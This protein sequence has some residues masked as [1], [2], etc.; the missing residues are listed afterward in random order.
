MKKQAVLIVAHDQPELLKINMRRLDSNRVDIYIHLDKKCKIKESDLT[1]VCKKSNVYI[2]KKY[3]PIWG[4]SP[5]IDVE[6]LL[7][8]KAVSTYEYSYYHLISGRDLLLGNVDRFCD[9]FENADKEFVSFQEDKILDIHKDRV[10][11]YYPFTRFLGRRGDSPDRHLVDFQKKLNINRIR[12]TSLVFQKG[13]NWFSITHKLALHV[14]ETVSDKK[15]RKIFNCTL[16]TDEVF[17]QT[18]VENSEFKNN[19]D[20]DIKREI[21]WN[22]GFPYTWREEDFDTLSNSSNF[23]ARKFDYIQFPE[24]VNMLIEE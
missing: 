20:S 1:G 21:D 19:V 12:N 11:Y 8:K 2:F 3:H 14:I 23:F 9:Y 24:I 10:K 15:F 6:V 17:L 4:T 13:A 7:L 5:M 22:R 18:I 16:C